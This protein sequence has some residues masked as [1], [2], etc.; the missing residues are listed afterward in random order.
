MVINIQIICFSFLA[1]DKGHFGST[2][3]QAIPKNLQIQKK[4]KIL[5]LG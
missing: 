3:P 2:K 1:F 5:W 4:N